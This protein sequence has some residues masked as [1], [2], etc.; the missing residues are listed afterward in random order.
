MG[1]I[2]WG[3]KSTVVGLVTGLQSVPDHVVSQKVIFAD[4]L[5]LGALIHVVQVV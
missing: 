5:T 2:H 3:L 1:L 4:P